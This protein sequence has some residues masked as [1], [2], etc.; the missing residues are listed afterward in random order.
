MTSCR[1][2]PAAGSFALPRARRLPRRARDRSRRRRPTLPLRAVPA[3]RHPPRQRQPSTKCQRLDG[4]GALVHRIGVRACV[5]R[6]PPFLRNLEVTGCAALI[7]RCG[8]VRATTARR[9]P[10][11]GSRLAP[12]RAARPLVLARSARSR[13]RRRASPVPKRAPRPPRARSIQAAAATALPRSRSVPSR[14]R[15]ARGCRRRPWRGANLG[16]SRS[17]WTEPKPAKTR[18]LAR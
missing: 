4:I 8:V 17:A 10:R 18:G 6:L 7:E 13:C 3:R 14:P 1:T 2:V 5:Q 11:D 12:R 9:W 16:R 15:T